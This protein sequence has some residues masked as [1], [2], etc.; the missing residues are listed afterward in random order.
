MF[1]YFQKNILNQSID[2]WKL[3]EA[4][5]FAG[6]I[7][8]HPQELKAAYRVCDKTEA[9]DSP[10]GPQNVIKNMSLLGGEPSKVPWKM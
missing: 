6:Y 8:D 7:G 1:R 3:L 9:W 5:W 10:D 2:C 4:V